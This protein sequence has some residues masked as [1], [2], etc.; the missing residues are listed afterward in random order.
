[1]VKW[2]TKDMNVA[3]KSKELIHMVQTS[4]Q[5]EGRKPHNKPV[6]WLT[7]EQWANKKERLHKF[8]SE[9]YT[10]YQKEKAEHPSFTPDQIR[11]VVLDHM[12]AKSKEKHWEEKNIKGQGEY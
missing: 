10:E 12:K 3:T 9:Y 2:I 7:D 5:P 11:T 8:Q 4:G 6:K 1:M